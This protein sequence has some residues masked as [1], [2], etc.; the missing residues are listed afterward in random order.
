MTISNHN[1]KIFMT[2]G[3]FL[4]RVGSGS[5]GGGFL[6]GGNDDMDGGSGGK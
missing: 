4:G 3:C 1:K 5:G 2:S 6:G